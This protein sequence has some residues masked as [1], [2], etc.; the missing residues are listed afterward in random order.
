[1]TLALSF[2]AI[3]GSAAFAQDNYEAEVDSA[4]VASQNGGSTEMNDGNDEPAPACIGDGCDGTEN[5]EA[6]TTDGAQADAQASSADSAGAQPH[7]DAS[8]KTAKETRTAWKKEDAAGPVDEDECT[9]ADSLLPECQDSPAEY[10]E[11]DDDTYDRYTNESSDI[12]RASREGFSSG[13]SLGF[14]IGGGFNMM[15]LGEE[16]D[17]WKI[18]Y[19]AT[20]SIATLTKLGIS[21]LYASAELAFGYYHYHYESSLEYED[22]SEDNDASLNIVLFEVPVILKYAIG[23]GNVTVGLGIDLGLK[24]TGSSDFTQTITTST[25]TDTDSPDEDMIPSAGVEFGGIFEVAYNVNKNFTVDVR[26]LQRIT[27][28]LN[29][30]VVG[31]TS[32]KSSKPLGT[33]ASI[34][35]SLFL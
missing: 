30:D 34:G 29:E 8:V 26:I 14:R 10:D 27:N 24:L 33:H 5:S 35:F 4:W 31:V 21:G 13:F 17:N 3:L 6:T 22:Y 16:V 9:P 7:G 11:D 23:S 15:M 28:L 20:A 12:T 25:H 19:G 2:V 32:I 1:M 18:G